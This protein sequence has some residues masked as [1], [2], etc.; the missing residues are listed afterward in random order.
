MSHERRPILLSQP[1]ATAEDEAAVLNA[2]RSGWL[3]PAGPALDG[4]EQDMANYLGVK[5]AVGVSSGTA[6]LHL[7]LRYVG[8][9]AGDFV[10]VPTVTF[11]ATAFAVTYLGAIPVFVDIE[12]HGWGMDS[13]CTRDAIEK[14]KAQGGRVTAAIPVDLYGSPADYGHL[15]PLLEESE[16]PLIEDA[17]EGLG[18]F[19]RDAKLG[20]LG[21]A[22]VLSFNGNKIITTSGGGMLVTNDSSMATRVR[23]WATQAREPVPWYEHEEIGHNYRLS[24]ILAALG[25]SQLHRID[26]EVGRRRA[27]REM[28]RDH[29]T[30]LDGVTVQDDPQW[31][32]SNAWLTV[33][34]FSKRLEGHISQELREHLARN[35]V[36]SRPLWKPLHLQPVF[37]HNPS[38]LNGNADALFAEG[39]CLPSGTALTDGEIEMICSHIKKFC[40][41]D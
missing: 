29:L 17:A 39:L 37:R 20:T 21:V 8:V 6:A 18:G 36:E 34:R 15:V 4:F 7:A 3:A 24:N 5:C 32:T 22:G 33:I 19:F 27:I 1:R 40:K 25:Q 28:Y 2:L 23:K 30:S 10:L 38:F 14:I 35:G 9:Q 31:G 13:D 12:E 26:Y 16:I 11:A 41:K